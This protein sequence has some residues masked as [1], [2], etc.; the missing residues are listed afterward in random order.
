MPLVGNFNAKTKSGLDYERWRNRDARNQ[1][2]LSR[3]NL[4]STNLTNL[5][6][7]NHDLELKNKEAA[8]I[9]LIIAG[10]LRNNKQKMSAL[11]V[12]VKPYH[13]NTYGSTTSLEPPMDG[14]F[15]SRN[16]VFTKQ[17]TVD[18]KVSTK[19]YGQKPLG[20]QRDLLDIT[21]RRGT[22]KDD[23]GSSDQLFAVQDKV[24]NSYSRARTDMIH[25]K[26]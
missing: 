24:Q 26:A 2:Q 6:N 14:K 19:R 5:S 15:Q 20:R 22:L 3:R 17:K 11:D 10:Q 7:Y 21:G 9:R 16:S 18:S 8:K 1:T 13:N 23:Y 25:N 4:A 12:D